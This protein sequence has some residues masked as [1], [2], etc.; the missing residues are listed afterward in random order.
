MID[1]ICKCRVS[2]GIDDEL[3]FGTGYLD[4][5]GFWSTPCPHHKKN[6]KT[7]SCVRCRLV[8]AIDR[9]LVIPRVC[10]YCHEIYQGMAETPCSHCGRRIQ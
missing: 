5:W 10:P 4:D 8:V 1:N 9:T 6:S 2:T 7:C 3:T